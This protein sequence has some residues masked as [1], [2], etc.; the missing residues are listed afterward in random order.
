[1][2][3]GLLPDTIDGK[4]RVLAPGLFVPKGHW[5]LWPLTVE[6]VVVAKDFGQILPALLAVE[7]LPVRALSLLRCD[8]VVTGEGLSLLQRCS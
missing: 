8:G 1:M 4:T 7:R 2:G 6:E 3:G 5:A